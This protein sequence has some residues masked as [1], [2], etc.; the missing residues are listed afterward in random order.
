MTVEQLTQLKDEA[1]ERAENIQSQELETTKY[2]L[3]T[4]AYAKK[5]TRRV[6]DVKVAAEK[7]SV[8]LEEALK[9]DDTS[10]E[11]VE[12]LCKNYA[13][14]A[15]RE[16]DVTDNAT[17]AWPKV[18]KALTKL[19]A[20]RHATFDATQQASNL[21]MELKIKLDAEK[22]P[23]QPVDADS[24]KREAFKWKL[25]A[26]TY[27]DDFLLLLSSSSSSLDDAECAKLL[28]LLTISRCISYYY[29]RQSLDCIDMVEYP[30][31]YSKCC[32]EREFTLNCEKFN[33]PEGEHKLVDRE[34]V[35]EYAFRRQLT[36]EMCQF[37]DEHNITFSRL[38][39]IKTIDAKTNKVA[40]K[41]KV[42]LLEKMVPLG[43]YMGRAYNWVYSRSLEITNSFGVDLDMLPRKFDERSVLGSFALVKD[44]QICTHFD[45]DD[46]QNLRAC[47]Q[48]DGEKEDYLIKYKVYDFEDSIYDCLDGLHSECALMFSDRD[49]SE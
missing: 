8:E 13:Y 31:V 11:Q 38:Q 28:S 20:S 7:A 22:Q 32:N 37:E 49:D 23:K 26:N 27:E 41:T 9:G 2:M 14:A 21:A 4:D 5:Q 44:S 48:D 47:I 12:M 19:Q 16:K 15:I 3:E 17:K 24:M 39:V 18:A 42:I 43:K 30:D 35:Y 33:L 46:D 10:V 6:F 45:R 29:T 25:L 1:V 36:K 34:T 40:Y